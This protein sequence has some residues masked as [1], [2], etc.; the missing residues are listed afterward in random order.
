[1]SVFWEDPLLRYRAVVAPKMHLDHET[2]NQTHDDWY[3]K[4]YYELLRHLI[5]SNTG[6]RFRIYIDIKDTQSATKLRMLHDVLCNGMHDFDHQYLESMQ[7]LHSHEV[8][9]IQLADLLTGAVSY[10]ARGLESSPAK[11]H[12]IEALQTRTGRPIEKTTWLS[13]KKF[14]V[15]PWEPQR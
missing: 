4:M 7:A 10:A 1:M 14:N 8:P 15:F 5:T 2:F 9:L 13:E 12:L 6:D 11:R 3:H